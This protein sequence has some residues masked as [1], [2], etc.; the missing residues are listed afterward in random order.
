MKRARGK[1]S[2]AP[3]LANLPPTTEA[4]QQNVFRARTQA[5]IWNACL[6]QDPPPMEAEVCI[7]CCFSMVDTSSLVVLCDFSLYTYSFLVWY[8]K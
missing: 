2:N 4:F 3:K 8:E 6:E 7:S 5:L 1:L